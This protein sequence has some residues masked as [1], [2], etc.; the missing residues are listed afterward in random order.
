MNV[1]LET[2]EIDTILKWAGEELYKVKSALTDEDS[3]YKH[4]KSEAVIRLERVVE[5]KTKLLMGKYGL[6]NAPPGE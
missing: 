6:T 3:D 1:Y 4:L 5:I 2:A